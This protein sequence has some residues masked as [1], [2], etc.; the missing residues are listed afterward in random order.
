[1]LG[2]FG[3]QMKSLGCVSKLFYR[4]RLNRSKIEL[5]Y[6]VVFYIIDWKICLPTI[7]QINF[8]TESRNYIMPEIPAIEAYTRII[9]LVQSIR[10]GFT[11]KVA[12]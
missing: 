11:F 1:M 6:V 5:Q 10:I 9:Y 8:Q 12:N 7:C 3:E 4:Q 2:E